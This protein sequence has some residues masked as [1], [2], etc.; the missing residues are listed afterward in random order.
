MTNILVTGGTGFLGSA[1]VKK[2]INKN[3]KVFIFDN[4]FRG[5]LKNIE[6][7]EKKIKFIKGDIRTP[8]LINNALKGN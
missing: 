3:N 4:N 8:N 7:L 2:L 5:N 1:L 6:N